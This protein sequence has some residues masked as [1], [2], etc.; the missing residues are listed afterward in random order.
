MIA[1]SA[2]IVVAVVAGNFFPPAP[3]W[4]PALVVLA[5]AALWRGLAR[6]P[7][8][9]EWWVAAGLLLGL[10]ACAWAPRASGGG[11]AIPVRF[12]VAIRDGWQPSTW[13]WRTRVKVE[14]LEAFG[15]ALRPPRQ[16]T[17]ALAGEA[18]QVQL[19]GPG[20]RWAGSGELRA[21]PGGPLR[22]PQLAVKSLLL[23]R[24]QGDG[25][26]IDRMREAGVRALQAAA[27]VDPDR[28]RT[29]GFVA[30]L[31]LGRLDGLSQGEVEALR[32]SGLAHLIAVSGL[33]VGLVAALIWGLLLAA[34][35]RPAAR[36]WAVAAGMI[37][38]AMLAGGAAPVTRAAAGGVAFLVA[39]QLGRPL[40]PLPAVWAVIAGLVLLEP[41]A[42]LQAGFQLSAVVTLALVRWVGPVASRLRLLP[43]WL[44][45]AV[46]V[47]LVAQ[48]A[49]APLVGAHFGTLP[50][51]GV[52]ANLLAAPLAFL[53]TAASLAALGAA[54]LGAVAGRVLLELTGV[55][56]AALDA[57][58][59]LGAGAGWIFA[60]V[61]TLAAVAAG[62]LG[63]WALVRARGAAWAGAA[64]TSACALWLVPWPVGGGGCEV[65]MLGVRDGMALLL[66]DARGTVLVDA[67]RGAS[68]AAAGLAAVGLRRLDALVITHPD[69]DHI[70][71]AA[72]VLDRF[73]V[74]ALALPQNAARAR[75]MAP[76][77]R[78]ARSRGVNEAT[79]VPGQRLQWGG[80]TCDVL[81]PPPELEAEDNDASLVA[82]FTLG[83]R[84]VLITGDLEAAGEA[85][86]LGGGQEL[87]AALLQLPHHGAATSSTARF[88]AAVRPLVA[89][90]A[91]GREPR[92]GHPHRTVVA[93]VRASGV[94]VAS[95]R[96][97]IEVVR[98]TPGERLR[99]VVAEEVTIAERRRPDD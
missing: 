31:V 21:L 94:L 45:Q 76:L 38:F 85:A 26:A 33:N 63:L 44:A 20:E 24:K 43:T 87:A 7:L 36:R 71:G 79:L 65:R 66:R 15:H 70:G 16:T 2:S 83:G 52:A 14:S 97:G 1:L 84:R 34:G 54:A 75:E 53:L 99:V 69:A 60:P 68:D 9:R 27:G 82:A 96:D 12:V 32:R 46:A 28:I 17:L 5:L 89:L 42:V 51:A 91:S 13:G 93:R 25:P 56:K 58:A 77:R 49:S 35:L 73:R 80:I 61:P 18:T 37:G 11:E 90:A 88:L 74:A 62:A 23:L 86:L 19:P 59:G 72:T 64:M 57:V 22:R 41:E 40:E 3:G 10:A 78:L 29:A 39:R 55:A 95:Q 48:V 92:F 50:P 30:A 4:W 47:T 8:G 6:S 81:W 98:W 67:G